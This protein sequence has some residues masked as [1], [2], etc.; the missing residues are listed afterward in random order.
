L[1]YF[2]QFFEVLLYKLKLLAVNFYLPVERV[3]KRIKS[4]S[5]WA[6]WI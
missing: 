1:Q 2:D 6:T 3:H 5:L 4:S